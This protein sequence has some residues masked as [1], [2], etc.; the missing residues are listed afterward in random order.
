MSGALTNRAMA[1]HT[2]VPAVIV[3]VQHAYV[4]ADHP[5]LPH[6]HTHL[7]MCQQKGAK[8]LL[9]YNSDHISHWH[10]KKCAQKVTKSGLASSEVGER[11]G[12]SN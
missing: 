12:R 8:P 2:Q 7:F 10:G 6:L 9:L 3:P 4:I 11:H 1:T 5:F